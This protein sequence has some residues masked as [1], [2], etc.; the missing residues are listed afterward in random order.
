MA[1]LC[2][3]GIITMQPRPGYRGQEIDIRL[4]TNL[5][6]WPCMLLGLLY[7]AQVGFHAGQLN[8]ADRMPKFDL[9]AGTTGSGSP[10]RSDS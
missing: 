2:F 4:L 10:T 7:S 9:K 8:A 6:F 1:G 5:P 3:N